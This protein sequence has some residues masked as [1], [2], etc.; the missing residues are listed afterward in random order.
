MNYAGFAGDIRRNGWQVYGAEVYENGALTWRFGDTE[1][2]RYP[3]YSA[4]KTVTALAVGLAAE[5]GKLRLSDCI[6]DHLPEEAA[7]CM[8]DAQR[9][10]YRHVTLR[11]L[12]TMSVAGYPFRPEGESWLRFSLGVPLPDAETP[13]FEYSN[14]PAYL[15][16]VAAAR[17][18]GEDLYAYL[19]RRLFA[20]LGI[21]RPPC[22]R[23]PEGYFYGATGLELTVNELSRLGRL[24]YQGG[25]WEG[26]RIVPEKW[27]REMSSVQQMNREG[28]Y[29]YFLWIYRSG[30]SMNGKWGQKCYILPREGKLIT[31]LSHLEEGSDAVRESMERH[32]LA[33]SA[34]NF[35]NMAGET[36]KM[37]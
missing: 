14:I 24:I 16:G 9:A 6:L 18:V 27:I 30:C 7:R 11:R 36:Q 12:L 17:A 31:F 34:K 2:T 29:G 35:E 8:E 21:I 32:L 13:R 19:D 37:G 15:A 4:T 22:A 33:E 25:V 3:I 10:A 5:E 1:E 26:R 20:P 23:C 28:G